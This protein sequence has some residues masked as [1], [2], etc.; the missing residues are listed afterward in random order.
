MINEEIQELLSELEEDTG[1]LLALVHT[2]KTDII[3]KNLDRA[4]QGLETSSFL[5]DKI[6]ANS[7]RILKL[8]EKEANQLGERE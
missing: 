6:G 8:I 2:I 7:F 3:L 4:K 5:S 1:R